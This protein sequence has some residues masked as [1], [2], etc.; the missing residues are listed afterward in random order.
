MAVGVVIA[1]IVAVLLVSAILS[2]I[3][4]KK[5]EAIGTEMRRVSAY[6]RRTSEK[7]RGTFSGRQEEPA[8]DPNEKVKPVNKF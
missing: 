1:I 4:Y 3:A 5:R 8:V 7:I 2:F 6:A